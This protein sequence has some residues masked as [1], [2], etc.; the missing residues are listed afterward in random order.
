ML[1]VGS[2]RRASQSKTF[3]EE[4]WGKKNI[5][6]LHTLLKN[7]PASMEWGI[8]SSPTWMIGWPELTPSLQQGVSRR[9][10]NRTLLTGVTAIAWLKKIKNPASMELVARCS[11]KD[12][13][14]QRHEE[15]HS[16]S[17]PCSSCRPSQ[18]AFKL[19]RTD[20]TVKHE[21]AGHS[22]SCS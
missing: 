1:T 10:Q 18:Q 2:G 11:H 8:H 20:Q 3:Q 14:H 6:T 4:P 12:G 5:A 15:M 19:E 13:L 22:H 7:K 17:L 16:S 21:L 9:K